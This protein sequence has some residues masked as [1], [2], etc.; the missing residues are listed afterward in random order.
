MVIWSVKYLTNPVNSW[1]V[2]IWPVNN[3]PIN[4]CPASVLLKYG[5]IFWPFQISKI[6]GNVFYLS[7]ID[8]VI[9]SSSQPT[10]RNKAGLELKA[11]ANIPSTR[12]QVMD[13]VLNSQTQIKTQTFIEIEC[14]IFRIFE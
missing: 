5:Q 6:Q 13:E 11:A 12:S 1:P 2:I 9:E 10:L 8:D 4:S 7:K 3:W 14:E